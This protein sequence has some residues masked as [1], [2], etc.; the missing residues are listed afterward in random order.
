MTIP[1]LRTPKG[2]MI[3]AMKDDGL[4]VTASTVMG[5]VGCGREYT[6]IGG[7]ADSPEGITCPRCQEWVMAELAAELSEQADQEHE[8]AAILGTPETVAE[9]REPRR[10]YKSPGR[11]RH[12]R[13][14]HERAE[15]RRRM[16]ELL[17]AL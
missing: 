13:V 9:P 12:G 14:I 5:V 7:D 4:Q 2:K 8:G 3:H 17:R 10:R 1:T 16:K 6:G 15:R 11:S